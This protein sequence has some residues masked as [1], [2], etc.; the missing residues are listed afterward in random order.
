[1]C[2]DVGYGITGRGLND[3]RCVKVQAPAD[4]RVVLKEGAELVDNGTYGIHGESA[5]CAHKH[6]VLFVGPLV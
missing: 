4:V 5:D 6:G 1:M 3:R 2:E